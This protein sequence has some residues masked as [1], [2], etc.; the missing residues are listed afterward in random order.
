M[1]PV[2]QYIIRLDSGLFHS[3]GQKNRLPSWQA[4]GDGYVVVLAINTGG[5]L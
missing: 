5:C 1:N 3:V 4:G 2:Y